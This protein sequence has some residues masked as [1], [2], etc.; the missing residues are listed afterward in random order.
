MPDWIEG[1]KEPFILN[2]QVTRL[3]NQLRRSR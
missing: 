3:E 1:S 2:R